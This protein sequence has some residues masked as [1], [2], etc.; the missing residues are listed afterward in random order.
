VINKLDLL[1]L[2]SAVGPHI[3]VLKIHIDIIV[4]FDSSLIPNLVQLAIK[5]EFLIFED[6][7]FGDIGNTVKLQYSQGMYRIAEWADIVTAHTLPGPSI[8]QG[9]KEGGINRERGIVLIPEMSSVDNLADETYFESSQLMAE[10]NLDV[11]IGLI[12]RQY[13]NTYKRQLNK[14]KGKGKG[15]GQ[16]ARKP[17]HPALIH[18]SPGIHCQQI[19]DSLGQQYMSVD[20]AIDTGTDILIVGRAIFHLASSTLDREELVTHA[21]TQ[22]RYYR[23]LGWSAYERRLMSIHKTSSTDDPLSTC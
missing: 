20:R 17:I 16:P 22:A 9:L 6:R 2:A 14:G 13:T 3:C 19:G 21:S 5:H 10:S 7:K 12:T 4:D 15:K 18:F 23:Q 8:I 11:V 1:T